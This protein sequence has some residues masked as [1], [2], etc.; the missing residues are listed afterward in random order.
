[1]RADHPRQDA[2]GAERFI[3]F[4]CGAQAEPDEFLDPSGYLG[5]MRLVS[6][7]GYTC[8]E[9]PHLAHL[10][11]DEAAELK[12]YT[13]EVGLVPWVTHSKVLTAESPD[14]HRQYRRD[15]PICARNAE[16]LSVQVIVDHVG[17]DGEGED[18]V[19]DVARLRESARVAADHG[20][21][22]AVENTL[23][24]SPE[25]TRRVVDAIGEPHVGCCC[26]TGHALLTGTPPQD[27]IRVMG[28]RLINT[29]LQDCFGERDDHLPPGIG[30]MD[31]PEIVKALVEIGYQRPWML[32]ISGAKA[33]RACP[34]VR[35]LGLEKVMVTGL[36]Y[37]KYCAA[38]HR[39]RT[40]RSLGILP[41]TRGGR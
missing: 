7:T 6:K 38:R 33:H 19:R 3:E 22:L 36:A 16:V 29:H 2:L 14:A 41:A 24:L 4:G 15:Q 32:E 17:V 11:A 20:L 21:E 8:V 26:D 12:G 31:W 39:P 28:D 40:G 1:M 25:Y 37:L 13:Q 34:D 27:A 5:A 9:Y 30:V 23:T 18:V 35:D 10:S